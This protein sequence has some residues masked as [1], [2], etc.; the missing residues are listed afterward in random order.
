MT[1]EKNERDEPKKQ[2]TCG[3]K[4]KRSKTGGKY[5]ALSPADPAM[6]HSLA[7]SQECF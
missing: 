7:L 2:L 6:P 4:R 5:P 1:D 3:T